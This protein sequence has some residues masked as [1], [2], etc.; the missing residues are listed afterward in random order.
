MHFRPVPHPRVYARLHPDYLPRTDGRRRT[1]RQVSPAPRRI[2]PRKL[3]RSTGQA[4][5]SSGVAAE[6]FGRDAGKHR[7]SSGETA[8]KPVRD[9]GEVPERPGGALEKLLRSLGTHIGKHREDLG[10]NL[11]SKGE[12]KPKAPETKERAQRTHDNPKPT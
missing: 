5:D 2:A 9:R 3:K 8:E 6:K 4:S 12:A 10:N 7:R 1:S 11:R